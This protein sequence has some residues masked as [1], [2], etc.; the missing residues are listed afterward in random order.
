MDKIPGNQ[1]KGMP[2]EEDARKSRIRKI[3]SM[4]YSRPDIQKAIY[5]FAKGRETIPRYFEGFGKRP[6]SVQYP[7]EIPEMAKKGATSFH[8]SEELWHDPL[9]IVTGMSETQLNSLRKGWDLLIDIDSKYLDYSKIMAELVI[10]LLKLH[11]IKNV[12]I[13]FSGSKG[14][15]IIVPW[16]AFPEI[17]NEVRTSDMFPVYPRIIVSY[18]AEKIK[19]EL[20]KRISELSNSNIYVRDFQASKEVMPDLILVSPRHLFRTPYSLHEKTSLSSV[21]LDSNKIREFQPRDADPL[22]AEVKNFLPES[23]EGEASLLLMQ[24][25][26]WN[27]EKNSGEDLSQ[28]KRKTDFQPIKI[29]KISDEYFPPSIK[30]ILAG[31]SDGRKRGLFILLNLFRSIGMERAELEKRIFEWNKKNPVPLKDGYIK[32]QIIWSYR[33]KVVSPPNYDK[34]Y[35]KGIGIVPDAEEIRLKNPINYIVRKSNSSEKT[36]SKKGKKTKEKS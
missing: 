21:A 8:C 12:G 30:K 36:S 34:D 9:K 23:R 20:V 5:E 33:N 4:Y 2:E 27:K 10:Q 35:Y 14:F 13:K 11:G 15:H 22:K 18:I 29:E 6:D 32:A 19:T 7:S 25:L 16:K 28:P 24:A 1:G 26:D 3:T 17:I 31:L